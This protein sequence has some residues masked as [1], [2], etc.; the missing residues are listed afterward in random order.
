M[1]VVAAVTFVGQMPALRAGAICF[2]DPEYF[3]DNPLVQRPGFSSAGQFL[4]E[5]LEP[6]TVHGYYQPLTMI[7]LMLDY[8]AGARPGHLMPT[9]R[10]SLIL[11][12]I[13]AAMITLLLYELLGHVWAAGIIGILFGLHPMTVETFTWIG[14][15]KTVLAAFFALPAI[16]CY[17]RYARTGRKAWFIGCGILF[18]LALMSKPTATPLPLCLLLLDIWPLNRIGR[19]ENVRIPETARAEARGSLD[20]KGTLHGNER[21]SSVLIEKVPLLIIAGIFAWITYESQKRTAITV[22]PGPDT[23]WHIPLILSHNIV[24]YLQR[25]VWPAHPSAHYPVPSDISL[26]NAAFIVGVAGT[27]V[28]MLGLAVSLRWTRAAAVGWLY[29]FVAIFPTMGVIGFTNVI[30]ADKFAYLPSVGLMLPA[31]ALIAWAWPRPRRRA[32]IVAGTCVAA[33]ALALNSR[34]YIDQWAN[35]EKL[36][37]YMV[38]M[39]PDAPT[40]HLFLGKELADQGRDDAAIAEYRKAI[41]LEPNYPI[42]H[43]NIG[44]LL[45][46]PERGRY[47]EAIQHY[48]EALRLKPDLHET[49]IAMGNALLATGDRTGAIGHYREAVKLRPRSADGHYNLANAL[50]ADGK[51][52]EAVEHFESALQ[53]KPDHPQARKNY[54]TVLLQLGRRADAAAQYKTALRLRADWYDVAN[55]LAWMHADR[56]DAMLYNPAEALRFAETAC[57][58]TKRQN[59]TCLGTLAVMLAR[60][61]RVA[62]ARRVGDEAIRLAQAAGNEK[63]AT[64]IQQRLAQEGMGR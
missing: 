11:H 44:L 15:R 21:L 20:A 27:A 29:F 40:V 47:A 18:V 51:A 53:H 43:L 8:A 38:G 6:S 46:K 2:D 10:T 56:S 59:P 14:E 30:A 60:N 63:L 36:F 13:N 50:F 19:R 64:D 55:Q 25:I 58:I 61:G 39:T 4:T 62:E 26:Q 22:L 34:A 42:A 7:T 16:L 48:R 9:H 41:E 37:R 5:V 52:A 45:A 31:A 35:T 17:V 57:A 54:G 49:H 3:V 24:F 32:A 28:L 12:A 33:I 1:V 23:W